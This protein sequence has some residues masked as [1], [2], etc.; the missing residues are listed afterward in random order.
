[1]SSCLMCLPQLPHFQLP[2]P[3]L[4]LHEVHLRSKEPLRDPRLMP[5]ELH[6]LPRPPQGKTSSINLHHI[7]HHNYNIL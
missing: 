1:M 3:L 5:K 4:P 2:A 6:V 7:F